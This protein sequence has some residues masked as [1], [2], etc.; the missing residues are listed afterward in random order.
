MTQRVILSAPPLATLAS[1][2]VNRETK[3]MLWL[4]GGLILGIWALLLMLGKSGFIHML[5]L[6]GLAVLTV[7]IVY[8]IRAAQG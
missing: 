7:Q 5:L 2:A 3:T 1:A 6:L 4:I 8:K